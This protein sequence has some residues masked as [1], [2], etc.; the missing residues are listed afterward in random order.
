MQT[1]R[2]AATAFT[3]APAA[4]AAKSSPAV[5]PGTV[6][7]SKYPEIAAMPGLPEAVGWR[8]VIIPLKPPTKTAGGILLTDED[9][10]ANEVLCDIGYVA[11]VGPSAYK[12]P[13][14]GGEAWCKV[15]DFVN[16][17][18]LSG[19]DILFRG[20]DDEIHRIHVCNDR[21][22][23]LALPNPHAIKVFT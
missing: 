2:L 21:D 1:K 14:F 13:R 6:P 23:L 8:I 18:R 11:A 4:K 17:G 15:G 22:V 20:T 7:I 16:Y 9:M 12:D 19:K 3:A 10:W 5:A